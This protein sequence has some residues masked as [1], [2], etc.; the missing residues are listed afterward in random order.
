M[1]AF[2]GVNQAP[3]SLPRGIDPDMMIVWAPILADPPMAQLREMQDG[4]YNLD[5][6]LDMN[7]ALAYKAEQIKEA[8]QKR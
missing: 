4:T 3:P 8:T 7:L 6:L 1:T 2:G 5:D